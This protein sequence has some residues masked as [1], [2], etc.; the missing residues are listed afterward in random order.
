MRIRDM[1]LI[2]GK[3]TVKIAVKRFIRPEIK[4]KSYKAFLEKKK[5]QK[6]D[7]LFDNYVLTYQGGKVTLSANDASVPMT[8]NRKVIKSPGTQKFADVVD[9]TCELIMRHIDSIIKQPNRKK[10]DETGVLSKLTSDV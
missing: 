7:D 5:I 9:Y 3:G 4:D 8:I 10:Y 1:Y 2:V 6:T